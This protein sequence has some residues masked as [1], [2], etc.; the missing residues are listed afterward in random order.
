MN[1]V[2]GYV[3]AN[4]GAEDNMSR[5]AVKGKWRILQ[6]TRIFMQTLVYGFEVAYLFDTFVSNETFICTCVISAL[7][8]VLPPTAL[9]KLSDLHYI[10]LHI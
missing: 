6:N 10:T 1:D 5:H 2:F 7:V 3:S 9:Y 4:G 8:V